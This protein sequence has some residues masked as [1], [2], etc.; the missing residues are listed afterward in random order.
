M[1]NIVVSASNHKGRVTIS[2]LSA[3]VCRFHCVHMS[4]CFSISMWRQHF[5]RFNLRFQMIVIRGI[6]LGCA[7]PAIII[8]EDQLKM[9][10]S[11]TIK[12]GCFIHVDSMLEHITFMMLMAKCRI[13][14]RTTIGYVFTEIITTHTKYLWKR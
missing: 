12:L 11:A 2:F 7:L 1:F 14:A 8:R 5:I 6:G 9:V 3:K 4:V 13:Y 10:V